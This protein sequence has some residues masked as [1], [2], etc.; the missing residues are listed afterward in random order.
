M[1]SADADAA[2][3]SA[4]NYKSHYGCSCIYF[5]PNKKMFIEYIIILIII[6]IK[7]YVSISV[8]RVITVMHQHTP[9]WSV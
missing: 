4:V 6:K 9:K 7:I 8:I 2:L 1:M 5:L 3:A